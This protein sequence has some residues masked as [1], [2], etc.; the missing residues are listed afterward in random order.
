MYDK[1]CTYCSRYVKEVGTKGRC[2][3]CEKEYI[4]IVS[5]I[6][7]RYRIVTTKLTGEI[8]V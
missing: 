8:H 3:S 4:V 1:R 5:N 6:T 7:K 2:I